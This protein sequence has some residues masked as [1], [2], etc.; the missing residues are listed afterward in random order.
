MTA[1]TEDFLNLFRTWNLPCPVVKENEVRRE[2]PL[3]YALRDF[4]FPQSSLAIQLAAAIIFSEMVTITV[5]S[6]S[7]CEVTT[8]VA[9][10]HAV[11]GTISDY[12][13]L[14]I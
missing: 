8:S 7:V 6:V 9:P 5:Q 14:P 12:E 3:I 10:L 4:L 1:N 13:P 11:V 2:A